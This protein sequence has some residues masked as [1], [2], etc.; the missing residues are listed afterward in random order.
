V[1]F[2]VCY[3]FFVL[4]LFVCVFVVCLFVCLLHVCLFVVLIVL[5]TV[6]RLLVTLAGG[7]NRVQIIDGLKAAH[8]QRPELDVRIPLF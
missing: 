5:N 2:V 3:V 1:L 6:F 4:C 7:E 8:T